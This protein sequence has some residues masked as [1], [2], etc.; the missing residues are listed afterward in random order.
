MPLRWPSLLRTQFKVMG[1]TQPSDRAF[2]GDFRILKQ[3][4]KNDRML[5][6][7]IEPVVD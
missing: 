2:I 7:W 6:M 1:L 3:N 5:D 4:L